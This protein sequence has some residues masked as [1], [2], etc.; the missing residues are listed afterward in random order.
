MK[1][2][3]ALAKKEVKAR[4]KAVS[5]SQ[6]KFFLFSLKYL[7]AIMAFMYFIDVFTSIYGIDTPIIQDLVGVSFLPLSF[8]CYISFVFKYCIWHRLFLYYIAA[9]NI[10]TILQDYIYIPN[11]IDIFVFKELSLIGIVIF[12]IV[13][14][15]V[16][17]YKKFITKSN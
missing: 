12:L 15:Y 1:N 6:Y 3:K 17:C 8:L 7:P 16:K 5:N 13:Y 9:I 11:K 4:A 10:Y 14:I 2:L